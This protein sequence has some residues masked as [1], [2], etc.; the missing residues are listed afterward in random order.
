M[1]SAAARGRGRAIPILIDSLVMEKP[2]VIV[3]GGNRTSKLRLA[4]GELLKLP[5]ARVAELRVV[6]DP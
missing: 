3:G 2:T 5:G 1:G 6:Q 4:P